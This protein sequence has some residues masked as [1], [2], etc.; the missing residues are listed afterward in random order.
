VLDATPPSSSAAP[1]VAGAGALVA[2]MA[3]VALAVAVGTGVARHF[4]TP[5]VTELFEVALP[6]APPAATPTPPEGATAPRP[7]LPRPSRAAP[8]PAAAQAGKVL[9]APDEVVDFGETV[10]SGNSAA[11]AGGTTAAAGTSTQAVRAGDARAGG[12]AGGTGS[13]A[14]ADRSRPPQL[15][16]GEQWDCPFPSEADDADL[17]EAKVVLRIDVGPDGRVRAAT[18][19]GDPG[20]GFAREARRCAFGKHW[21]PGLDRAG[22]AV[23]ATTVVNVR[24]IR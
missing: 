17:N 7:R 10:V 6:A 13:D 3:L 15:A 18:P 19:V 5:A 4:A 9:A 20:H 24:F 12:G 16:G 21:S 1:L 8:P 14:G 11:Y 23:A 2:H 22:R